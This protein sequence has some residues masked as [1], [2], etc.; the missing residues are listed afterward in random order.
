VSG[1]GL[2]LGGPGRPEAATSEVAGRKR[3]GRG[4]VPHLSVPR[5]SDIP[6]DLL[7]R[8]GIRAA[9]FDLDNTLVPYGSDE[10]PEDIGRW[11]ESFRAC[12]LRGAVVS[13]AWPWRAGRVA[14]RLGW[15]AVAG[16]PKPSLGRLRRAMRVLGSTPATTALV[17]D[18]L[19]TDV[20]PGN[21]LGLFTV[22][23][24]PLDRREFVT[25]RV[26]RWLERLAG[27]GRS[28]EPAGRSRAPTG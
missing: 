24:E 15:P 17:G 8:K 5:V 7:L 11:L 6:L 23:V 4:W 3:R 16:W 12:G 26:A 10:V 27:R 25:T 19:F 2:E 20:W 14:A 18:Q 1:K 13:N 28:P 21:R 9:V 22:L